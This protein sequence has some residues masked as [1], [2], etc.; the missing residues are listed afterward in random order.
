[1]GLKL[2]LWKGPKRLKKDFVKDHNFV[3]AGVGILELS[4]VLDVTL[5]VTNYKQHRS[6]FKRCNLDFLCKGDFP[7]NVIAS[8]RWGNNI[9]SLLARL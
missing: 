1:M 5:I 4:E 9:E 6:F 3:K 7:L 2:I 8:M